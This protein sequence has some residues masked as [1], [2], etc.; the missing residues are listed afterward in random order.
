[1]EWPRLSFF[2][3]TEQKERKKLTISDLV[4]YYYTIIENDDQICCILS[5]ISKKEKQKTQ[6]AFHTV[7]RLLFI[8]T[9]D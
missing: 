2:I 4:D 6:K 7:S 9:V 5:S 3:Q 8:Q 1:M